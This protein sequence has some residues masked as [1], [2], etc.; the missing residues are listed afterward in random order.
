MAGDF[1]LRHSRW[2]PGERPDPHTHPRHRRRTQHVAHSD[3]LIDL[4]ET[5][6][7]LRLLNH[8]DGPS[9]WHS[10]NIKLRPGVLDLVWANDE[11]A[12]RLTVSQDRNR[13][14]HSVL[15]WTIPIEHEFAPRIGI[16]YDSDE[17]DA[18]VR[19]VRKRL[20]GLPLSY[21]SAADVEHYATYVDHVFTT[22]W[23]AHA[24]P[25]RQTKYSKSWWNKTCTAASRKLRE[26]R[27]TAHEILRQRSAAR[28]EAAPNE[29]LMRDLTQ[30]L[31]RSRD[32]VKALQK[33]FSAAVRTAKRSF[34][35][36]RIQDTKPSNIWDLAAWTRPRKQ[37][38]AVSIVGHDGRPADTPET[39][40]E[41]F[42]NQFTPENP[43]PVDESILD[44]F[45]QHPTR[46][47]PPFSQQELRNAL[48]HTSNSSAPGPDQIG[49]KWL[50]RIVNDEQEGADGGESH[51]SRQLPCVAPRLLALYDACVHYAIHPTVFKQSV[52]VVIP[53]P[54]KPDY[55]KAKAYRPIV[56]LNC[57]GKLLEKMIATRLQFDSQ[58]FGIAHPCQFGGTIQHSTTDAGVQL[59]HN[60]RQAW[61]QQIDSSALL[62]DVS[63][64]FPSVHH[65]LLTGIL[66]RQGFAP[67]LCDYF[68]NYL[69][70]RRTNFLF[71]G[72]TMPPADFSTG[73][74]QGSPLSPILTNLYIAPV[75]HKWAN[76]NEVAAGNATI[77]FFVDDGLIHV[78]APKSELL[79]GEEQLDLNAA[80]ISH[81]FNDL[82][83]D[84]ERTGL[85]VEAD[86]FE[87]MHFRRARTDWSPVHPLGPPVSVSTGGRIVVVEP[88]NAMRY[89][90]FYLDPAL[91]FREHVRHYAAKACSTV[92]A[93][94]ML[95]NSVRGLS[96]RDKRR[97]YI[98]NVLPVM[99]YGAQLWWEPH[100]KGRKWITIELQKAQ[101][102]A[103]RWI[104]GAFRTTPIGAMEMAAALLPI[105]LQINK[106]MVKACVRLTT[107]HDGHPLR[108]HMPEPWRAAVR[109]I[110]APFPLH[111][112]DIDMATSPLAH[113]HRVTAACTEAFSVLHPEC[114][115]GDRLLDTHD[116][117]ISFHLEAP[118]KDS[119]AFGV[120]KHTIFLPTVNATLDDPHALVLFTDGSK[121]GKRTGAAWALSTHHEL[122]ASGSF[123][124]GKASVYDAEMAALARGLNAVN[125]H[126]SP[127]TASLHVFADNK[128]AAAGILRGAPGPAQMLS[129]LACKAVR[130]FLAADSTRTVH[131]HW[132]PAH[133]GIELN[134]LVD[135]LAKDGLRL[136]QPEGA[137]ITAVHAKARTRAT[138]KWRRD[139]LS[140]KYRG[141]SSMVRESEHSQCSARPPTHLFLAKYGRSP[142]LMARVVRFTTGH[143]P[144]GEFRNKFNLPGRRD[145]W[146]GCPLETRDH[147]LYECPLWIRTAAIRQPT[148]DVPQALLFDPDDPLLLQQYAQRVNIDQVASFLRLN[149]MVATFEW[150][151]VV[152][153]AHS[154]AA[155]TPAVFDGAYMAQAHST[156]RKAAYEDWR[157]RGR[158]EEDFAVA[159]S[160]TTVAAKASVHFAARQGEG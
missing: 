130:S 71:N 84:L 90:G 56:L 57:I 98:S 23:Q 89:L 146:C 124:Y 49:W 122:R 144:H 141:H 43:T 101:S 154:D 32:S 115:P 99:T 138:R 127:A 157:R 125:Q 63:Q 9:T 151:D 26:A 6:L 142:Q 2:D 109:N 31:Q 10:N 59:V 70:G 73:V 1:N 33:Q 47:F 79:D 129:V 113:A 103:A 88:R 86:K 38:A 20:G 140:T 44:E 159:Y 24:K 133:V 11:Q 102:R 80:I 135:Q 153:K 126:C 93:L 62:F 15:S 87:L 18:F 45:P 7:D 75:L 5:H 134:E 77:Q 14:D 119:E 35:D 100:W 114:R 85:R 108:A 76:V 107:L 36:Q 128:A 48:Q 155:L 118:T 110:T 143:F 105:R 112:D 92:T 67:T 131:I 145:C 50:K 123:G 19:E 95:G 64:F 46:E 4:A 12:S 74:G 60:I 69:S 121:K 37:T 147:I 104:T 120:W 42:Q 160:A 61:R 78:A 30:R 54:N 3:A 55:S 22:Q 82:A 29:V 150:H 58:R 13:S 52:T 139:M 28:R 116:H 17:A 97:L 132:C 106:L 65:A 158:R 94:R 53:K 8:P 40:A 68:A 81:L 66:R 16:K 149:P 21:A 136:H 25:S 137:T 117:R 152:E 27:A 156:W 39:L 96:P 111:S 148:A 41:A 51:T 83:R 91:T 34:F 72:M